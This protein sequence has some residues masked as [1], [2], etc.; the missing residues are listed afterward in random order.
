M[1]PDGVTTLYQYDAR[2]RL[3]YTAVDLNNNGVIDFNGA[4]RITETLSDVTANNEGEI[5]NRTR[6]FVWATNGVAV[7]NL[8]SDAETSVESLEAWNVLYNNGLSL[9]N[10]SETEHYPGGSVTFS[11]SLAPD[12]SSQESYA[13][14]GRIISTAR[15]DANDNEISQAAYD[16]DALGRPITMAD[17]R[18]GVTTSFYNSA[19][20]V[21]AALT[22]SPDAVQPGQLTTNILDTLGRVIQ[23]IQPDG[24]S[25]TNVY[26][27][28]GLLQ[29]K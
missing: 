20:Q 24:T 10:Y 18:N 19:D 26:Y 12:G 17:A 21:V 27:A 9:T 3:V 5:V 8:V 25:V 28:N 7:S 29:E 16:Y 13:Q 23:T 11:T 14:Y 22:P 1:D 15:L 2:G 4:D 6:T